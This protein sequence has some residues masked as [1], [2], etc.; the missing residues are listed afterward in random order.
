MLGRDDVE[1]FLR[2]LGRLRRIGAENPERGGAAGG[3]KPLAAAIGMAPAFEVDAAGVLALE[4]VAFELLRGRAW[5]EALQMR[6][7][8]G[9]KLGLVTV[10]A[11]IGA[12]Q[13]Q[14]GQPRWAADGARLEVGVDQHRLLRERIDP[15]PRP[16]GVEEHGGKDRRDEARGET[17][18]LDLVA[19]EPVSVRKAPENG[20]HGV[21][22]LCP[23]KGARGRIRTIKR[24]M[25]R[26]PGISIERHRQ[27]DAWS[28]DTCRNQD[29]SAYLPSLTVAPAVKQIAIAPLDGPSA[30]RKTSAPDQLFLRRRP[31]REAVSGA[32]GRHRRSAQRTERRLSRSAW[33]PSGVAVAQTT[34]STARKRIGSD[35]DQNEASQHVRFPSVR[36]PRRDAFVDEAAFAE[37]VE[38]EIGGQGARFALGDHLGR[39]PAGAGDGLEA[40]RPPAAVDEAVLQRGLRDDGRAVAGHVHD[41]AP[42]AEHLEPRDDRE[43]FDQRADGFLDMVEAAALGVVVEAVG[44][45]ADHHLA[46][47]RLAHVAVHRVGH[48]DHIHAGL[49]RFGDERLEGDGFDG[50]TEARHVG[51]DARV[52]RNDDGEL[53]AANVALRR[54]DARDFAGVGADARHL[55]LLD[56]VHPHGRAGAGIAPGDGIVPRGAAASLP[57]R[58]EDGV[59]GAPDL[60]DRAEF[61][62]A[63]GRDEL[64]LDTLQR[65]GVFGALVA[66]DFV[67]GLGEHHDAAG[68]EHDVHVHVL[69]HGLIERARFLVDRR[70]RIL[71]VVRADDG[72][73]P[74]RVAA[75]EPALFD[76]RDIGDAVVLAEPVGG[77]EAVPP[78]P[79]D[80]HIVFLPGFG[81]GPGLLPP[82]VEA[83]GLPGHGE[84]RIALHG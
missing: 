43:G 49:D 78:C 61:L 28:R 81:R 84:D 4:E 46:L 1:D 13:D 55:A 54:L 19:V 74:A 64:C 38:A 10:D 65:V 33:K 79:D 48:D 27:A 29:R 66:P 70:R 47:V 60:D 32:P 14:H 37:A 2:R 75:A 8:T 52:A 7:A 59:A 24:R 18:E 51:E 25:F 58:A 23:G 69:A 72:G 41:A 26:M 39:G 42:L 73:V 21:V 9:L 57:E 6:L 71:Q 35:V 36:H 80:D 3:E 45:A 53:V 68:A 16:R 15:L 50:K 31:L 20:V 63:L 17:G 12:G 62:H 67:F 83:H 76:H 34:A 77:G 22:S 82:L 30:T 11:A 40:A 56:D 44:A 5:A